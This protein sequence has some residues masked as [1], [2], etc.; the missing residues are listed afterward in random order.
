M[1]LAN[2]NPL[3]KRRIAMTLSGLSRATLARVPD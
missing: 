3:A 1:S 2:L